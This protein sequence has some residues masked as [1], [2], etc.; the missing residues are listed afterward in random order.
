M[1][2][3]A[4]LFI[5]G[6]DVRQV[7]GPS[8]RLDIT[9]AHFSA[10]VTDPLPITWAPHLVV[11]VHCPD[12]HSGTATLEV[13]YRRDG[14]IEVARFVQPL[15]VE[16]AKFSYRLVR[17]EIDFDSFG[18]VRAHCRIDEGPV[19][20]VPYTLLAPSADPAVP[21]ADAP[22]PPPET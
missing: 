3:L 5:E 2:I 19:T 9:G 8:A 11:I 12:D 17:G 4:A 15:A 22:A 6:I 21:P 14:D 10:V 16:P 18:T 13:V 1:H 7:E 20:V